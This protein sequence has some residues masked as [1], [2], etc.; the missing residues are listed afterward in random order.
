M[1][2]FE[3]TVTETHT[4]TFEVEAEDEDQAID[5]AETMSVERSF[6]QGH[7]ERRNRTIAIKEKA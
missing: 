2:K 4:N 5:A 3:L 6:P 7:V 1:P